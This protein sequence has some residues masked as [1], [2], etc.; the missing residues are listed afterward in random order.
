MEDEWRAV[1]HTLERPS[2]TV[3]V[4]GT[5]GPFVDVFENTAR[6]GLA[7]LMVTA[8]LALLATFALMTRMT[9]S[10]RHLSK[11]ARAISS[12]D[13][14]Q[15]VA[16]TG[17]DEVSTVARAFNTMTESLDRTLQQLAKRE[18]LAAVGEFA[19][20]LAHEVRNPLTSI[21]VD[22]QS[23]EAELPPDSPLREPHG[24]ALAEVRRLNATVSDALRVARSG[25]VRVRAM[26]LR[27]P[28]SAAVDAALP[29]FQERGATLE[30]NLG[31]VPISLEGDP[32]ALEQL[33]LNLLLNA[34]E[35]L[36][37]EGTASVQVVPRESEVTVRFRDDGPGMPPEVR[38]RAFE[39]LFSTRAEGTG[40]GLPIARRIAVAHGGEIRI[41]SAPESGTLV[42]VRLP[43]T[44]P[45]G[46]GHS[47]TGFATG[48]A[49]SP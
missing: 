7:G 32:D 46:D 47:D 6:R 38:D 35:A 33:F 19:A 31:S 29:R 27:E 18:S 1:R 17:T 5:L 43:C 39:P 15:S 23:M 37:G 45:R 13:L 12:G 28:L 21:Q 36:E 3:V 20:G 26:D 44:P 14:S 9:R 2:L 25:Q 30:S 49:P 8:L 11:A 42:E 48:P 22:L 16:E 4:A 24:K 10:L 34:G 41:E 40:L